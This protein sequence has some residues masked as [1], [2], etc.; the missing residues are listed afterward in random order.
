[1]EANNLENSETASIPSTQ[2]PSASRRFGVLGVGLLA[3]ATLN[4]YL[5]DF[6]LYPFVI[7][8]LGVLKGGLVMTV[9]AGFFCYF[10]LCFY[11]WSKKDWL[12]IE[13]LKSLKD[14][15]GNSRIKK[16][17]AWFLRRSEPVILVFLSVRF[18]AFITTLYLRRGSHQY[19]GL[20]RNDWKI[21]FFSLIVS[22][23]Y[24]TLASFL[25]ITLIE[26]VWLN[27]VK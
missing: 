4:T 14:Y 3:N 15:E 16:I 21:F 6:L 11:D 19:N 1:M 5:F 8:K 26:Y 10:L 9:L 24:W 23:I 2:L 20:S 17:T 7:W 27:I 18:D 13:T 22:N 12:G 25:G